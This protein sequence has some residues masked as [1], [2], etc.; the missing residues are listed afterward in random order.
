MRQ[1]VKQT[2]FLGIVAVAILAGVMPAVA[3]CNKTITI[4]QL[5]AIR[6]GTIAPA[7]AGGR[8]T[9]AATG[10]ESAPSGF[11][12]AGGAAAGSFRVTGTNSCIVSIAFGAGSLLGP[13][14]AM[15]VTNFTT[16]A[17]ANPKLSPAGGQLTF[18][19]GADLVVNAGQTGGAYNGTYTI[20]VTY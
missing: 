10:S 18:A 13:G 7:T 17:G 9:V 2:L 15:T 19:V 14:T 12:L 6:F 8:V 1:L 16:N 20:T 4:T 5:Q 3:A 11:A